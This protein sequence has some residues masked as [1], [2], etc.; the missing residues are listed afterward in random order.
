MQNEIRSTLAIEVWPGSGDPNTEVPVSVGLRM[1][2]WL[3]WK[4]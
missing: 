2:I 4:Q 3:L 1:Y